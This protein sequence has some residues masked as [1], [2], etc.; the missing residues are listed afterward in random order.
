MQR[1]NFSVQDHDPDRFRSLPQLYAGVIAQA[2]HA[3]AL[4]CDTCRVAEPRLHEYDLQHE[5]DGYDIDPTIKRERFDEAPMLVER[6]PCGARA[7]R[8]RPC[9]QD[10]LQPRRLPQRVRPA[11]RQGLRRRLCAD[12]P[13]DGG[14]AVARCQS[15]QEAR[16][17]L[18]PPLRSGVRP[19]HGVHLRGVY[20]RHRPAHPP[21]ASSTCTRKTMSGLD[22]RA[23]G[24]APIRSGEWRLADTAG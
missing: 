1:S 8:A 17:R 16:A 9:R 7:G 24:M 11:V 13:G 19:P 10:R 2:R 5:L 3:E 6:L 15:G 14:R 22:R 20:R 4:G 18:R 21:P 12:R 23:R